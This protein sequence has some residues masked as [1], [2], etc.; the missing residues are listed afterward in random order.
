MFN[1]FKK[2]SSSESNNGN[3][4]DYS[5]IDSKQKALDLFEK[6]ELSKMY[7]MPLEFGG[8]DDPR[9]VLYV[10]EFAQTIKQRF[11]KMIGELLM[12]GK[13]LTYSAQPEYKGKSFIPSKLVVVAD[14]DAQF[15]EI[16][17]IW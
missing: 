9:N 16:I 8:Q 15:T 13:N 17:N 10:P 1:W 14:G 3:G 4:P 5:N 2:K 11:D 12:G 7:L 6:G